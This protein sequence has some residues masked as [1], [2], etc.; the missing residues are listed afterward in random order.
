MT[1]TEAAED[2]KTRVVK[3]EWYRGLSKYEK[4]DAAMAAGQILDTFL[5][6]IGL[7]ALMVWIVNTGRPMWWLILPVIITAGLTV[8]IFIIQHDCGHGS[9]FKSHTANRVLGY[10][11]GFITFTPYEDWRNEHAAHH[12]TAQNLEKRGIGDIFTMTTEEFE[13]ASPGQRLYYRLFRNPL[14]L[15]TIGPFIQF[16]VK[17]RFPHQRGGAKEH[18]SV[19]ITNAV[20]LAALAAAHFTIGLKTYLIIQLPIIAVAASVGVW[21]FYVQ[22]QYE[23]VYWARQQNWDPIRAA[24]E[25]SSYY[26]LPKILQWFSGNIGFHHIHHLR[27]RIPNYRLEQCFNEVPELRDCKTLTLAESIRT[28]GMHL[29]DEEKK[30]LISFRAHKQQLQARRN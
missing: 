28:A 14:F 30:E 20:L 23:D 19:Y 6:Y 8:R 12:A 18:R 22:H 21:M 15:F 10:L 7:W 2:L 29:W 4:P 25:G 24:L 16:V 11:C 13:K 1:T 3:S 17:H 9:F 5:P 26:R 27:P